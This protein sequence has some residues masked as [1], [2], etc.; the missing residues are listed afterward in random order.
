MTT[1]PAAGPDEGA[2]PDE[3]AAPG[4]AAAPDDDGTEP[5]PRVTFANERTFLAWSRTALALVVA[6]LGVVQL[7]PPFPGVPWGRRVL[8]LP[9]I[10]F[11]AVVAVAAYTEWVRNQRALRHGLPLP[12]SVMPRLLA[13]VIA[14]IAVLAAVV[15]LVSAL[16]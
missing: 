13:V 4:G 7:L 16:R 12:H 14:V 11:G 3:S 6:G 5:D 15:V 1:S 2:A 8:G 10:V 9:L